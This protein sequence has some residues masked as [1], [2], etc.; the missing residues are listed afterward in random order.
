MGNQRQDL[1]SYSPFVPIEW[2]RPYKPPF[3]AAELTLR[4]ITSLE[5]VCSAASSTPAV[6]SGVDMGERTFEEMM[7]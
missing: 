3:R 4:P 7:T 5:G 6:E 2:Q 1:F